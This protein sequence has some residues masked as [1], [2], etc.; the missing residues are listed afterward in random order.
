MKNNKQYQIGVSEKIF[1]LIDEE[2]KEADSIHTKIKV[3]ENI[4]I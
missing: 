2:D 3:N 4:K 1:T